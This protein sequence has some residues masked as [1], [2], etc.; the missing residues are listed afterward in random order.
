MNTQSAQ[1]T[2][3]AYRGQ[4]NSDAATQLAPFYH[5]LKPDRH[6]KGNYPFRHRAYSR[7][8]LANGNRIWESS[9]EFMQASEINSYA[10]GMRR[11]F[12]SVPEKA[13]PHIEKMITSVSKEII[14]DD[15]AYAIGVHMI[16]INAD[17]DQ[18]GFPAPE[19]VHQD[20]FDYVMTAVINLHNVSGAVSSVIR[21]NEVVFQG[22]VSP[23]EYIMFDD[24]THFHYVSPVTPSLPGKAFRDAL[25]LTF[26]KT[27]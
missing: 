25:I 9:Q 8:Q 17:T 26:E 5:D 1:N 11:E 12:D 13:M 23:N 18:W 4:L 10:G 14:R 6:I 7:G 20:G 27:A 21:D 2:P 3:L 19:G 24:R 22:A 16:R 15:D